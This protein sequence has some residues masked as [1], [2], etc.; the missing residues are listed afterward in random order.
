[1]KIYELLTFN[2][3]LL[4]RIHIAGIKPEDYKY[5]D[6]FNEY[7][8]R[9]SSGEKVTYIVAI[10]S[11]KFNISERKVYTLIAKFNNEIDC[12]NFRAVE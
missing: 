1:M 12:C 7:D 2:R 8:A 4:K 3:E 5:L 9:L 6:L 10:L 11:E